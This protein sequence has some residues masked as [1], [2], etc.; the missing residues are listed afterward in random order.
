MKGPSCFGC[1]EADILP[2]FTDTIGVSDVWIE[3]V[4][5]G[6]TPPVGPSL[7]ACE[8]FASADRER[9]DKIFYRSSDAVTLTPTRHEVPS[10]WVD[11]FGEQLSDHEPVVA[12]FEV[13]LVPEPPRVVL[14]TAWFT[15]LA[16]L[17]RRRLRI[18]GARSASRWR[19]Q[20]F[21]ALLRPDVRASSRRLE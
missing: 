19:A 21:L 20:C 9:V 6:S 16:V 18:R 7:Q 13:T 4:R 15:S 10:D 2:E 5:A 12:E 8:D 11:P 17:A 3:L 14:S 1:G